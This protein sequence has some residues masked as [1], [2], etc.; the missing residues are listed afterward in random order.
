MFT[1]FSVPLTAVLL[2]AWFGKRATGYS[3]PG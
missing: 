1:V 2:K 3:G